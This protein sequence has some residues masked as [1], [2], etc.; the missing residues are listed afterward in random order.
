MSDELEPLW[1]EKRIERLSK[2]GTL[3]TYQGAEDMLYKMP[4]PLWTDEMIQELCDKRA[5]SAEEN[6][7][8]Y[9]ALKVMSA[10]Y[11]ALLLQI[12][13]LTIAREKGGR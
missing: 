8:M 2:S 4:G 10:T 11:Q 1:D 9:D 13:L 7:R 5:T 12:A 3:D 6:K